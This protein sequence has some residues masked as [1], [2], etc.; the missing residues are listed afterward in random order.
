MKV[1]RSPGFYAISLSFFI[2]CTLFLIP[3]A[4]AQDDKNLQKQLLRLKPAVVFVY[5]QAEGVVQVGQAQYKPSQKNAGGSGWIVSPDGYLVTNG[6][7]V[8]LYHESN[9]SQLEDEMFIEVLKKE[10]LPKAVAEFQKK[11]KRSPTEPE[12]MLL[13]VEL[14]KKLK[15]LTK[16][17]IKKDLV[18]V[19]PNGEFFQAE[20]KQYSPP[21]SRMP[22]KTA[23]PALQK[24][25][26]TG[27]DVAILK[28]EGKN[29]PTVKLG[30]SNAAQFGEPINIMGYPGV[31]LQHPTLSKKTIWES[32]VTSG[33]I[34]GSKIDIKGTPVIQTDAPTTWGNSGGPGFNSKGE[35]IGMLTF[36]SIHEQTNQ[37]IQ[38]FNFLVPV[39]TV[40]EFV[41]A[42]GV[43][44][45]AP[46]LFNKLWFETLDL[47][48]EG[49][50]QE[51][52]AKID[53]VLR[54]MPNQPDAR[55]IQLAAQ[56]RISVEGKKT[57]VKTIL[58][59]VIAVIVVLL[60]V[61]V[62]MIVM[63]GKKASRVSAPASPSMMG[64]GAKTVIA[65]PAPAASLVGLEGPLE[66]KTFAIRDSGVRIGRDPGKNEI[67]VS[68]DG[69][70]KEHARI[71]IRDGKHVVQDLNSLNGTYINSVQSNRVKEEAL[72]DGDIIIIGSGKFASFTYKVG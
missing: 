20:I 9:E 24:K 41:R 18:V 51:T 53:E 55:K 66:G 70:S 56:E 17:L 10:F 67:V 30:D 58:Y 65:K 50:Y 27:K 60:I 13:L 22:G 45:N 63:K 39:N 35:V 5:A 12:M 23:I 38:G 32:S 57:P 14:Y 47:Y 37:A 44:L 11:Q 54:L 2:L 62:V 29:L 49:K 25:V 3:R 31:V 7:V 40:K 36:G 42:T 16:V 61:A 1:S 43:D 68:N 8:E 4:S 52:L 26:E 6:H 64:A 59:I 28:I 33:R 69:V 46:S 34:S 72:K 15:P 21:M 48:S 19:L 71:E